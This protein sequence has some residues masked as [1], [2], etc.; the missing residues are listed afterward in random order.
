MIRPRICSFWRVAKG[1]MFAVGGWVLL[2]RRVL[3][4]DLRV[5]CL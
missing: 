3:R 1:V 5:K 4:A 2:G